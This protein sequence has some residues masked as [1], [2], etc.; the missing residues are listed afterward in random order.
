MFRVFDRERNENVALKLLYAP[1]ATTLRGLRHEL[2]LMQGV[3][4]P[5]LLSLYDV[6][7]LGDHGFLCMELV[8]GCDLQSH[9]RTSDASD[10]D[11]T[12][13]ARVIALL[14]GALSVLHGRFLV[15]RDV[16]PSNVRLRADGTPVLL[17]YGLL[18]HVA[19]ADASETGVGTPAYMS[20]EQMEG[21]QVGPA[22]DLYSLGVMLH[23]LLTGRLPPSSARWNESRDTTDPPLEERP[24]IPAQV[25]DLCRRLLSAKSENRPVPRQIVAALGLDEMHAGISLAPPLSFPRTFVARD[26]QLLQMDRAFAQAEAQGH[27]VRI[28]GKPQSGKSALLD[29]AIERMR[30]R[31][32]ETLLLRESFTT[33]RS[34]PYGAID[35]VARAVAE[36][37]VRHPQALTGLAVERAAWAREVFPALGSV[38]ALALA[39]SGARVPDLR[40][41]RSR[42]FAFVSDLLGHLARTKPVIVALDDV[43]AAPRD[44]LQL[45]EVLTRRAQ[46]GLFWIATSLPNTAQSSNTVWQNIRLP[47]LSTAELATLAAQ[48][49][50]H[51]CVTP[52]SQNEL[53]PLSGSP[54]TLLTLVADRL[55]GGRAQTLDDAYLARISSLTPEALEMLQFLCAVDLE[56][57]REELFLASPLSAESRV[58]SL[59]RLRSAALVCERQH[60]DGRRPLHVAS[61]RLRELVEGQLSSEA[62]VALAR[63]WARAFAGQGPHTAYERYLCHQRAGDVE[64]AADSAR[65]LAGRADAALGFGRAAELKQQ[66]VNLPRGTS[67]EVGRGDFRALGDTLVLDGR[68]LEAADA[69]LRAAQ[70]ANSAER[71]DLNRRRATLL[72]RSGEVTAGTDAIKDVLESLGLS[73]PS[74]SKRALFSLLWWRTKL[75]FRGLKFQAKA[76]TMVSQLDLMRIDALLSMANVLGLVDAFRG[77]ELQ[78]R[79]LFMALRAGESRH[80]ARALVQEANAS[81]TFEPP[82]LKKTNALLATAEQLLAHTDDAYSRALLTMTRGLIAFYEFRPHDARTLL[83]QAE[84]LFC[85]ECSDVE[86][87]LGN[88]RQ[89]L[90]QTLQFQE[91]YA[92]LRVRT[93]E[94]L[95]EAEA[96]GD[97]YVVTNLTMLGASF[98]H[99]LDS[100]PEAALQGVERVMPVWNATGEFYLQHFF[101]LL[102]R[103]SIASHAH[104]RAGLDFLRAAQAR[105]ERS[106]LLKS[107]LVRNTMDFSLSQAILST[108][109]HVAIEPTERDSLLKECAAIAK[110]LGKERYP[111]MALVATTID[112]SIAFARG[113]LEVAL[114][115]ADRAIAEGQ[116]LGIP[117]QQWRYTIACVRGD[118]EQAR[119]LADEMRRAGVRDPHR[120]SFA[121]VPTALPY[122]RLDP[123]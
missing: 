63:A 104:S 69:Y 102:A 28:E 82:P 68:P 12:S 64:L 90:L 114:S 75:A 29:H 18:T 37:L 79:A 34:T 86:W 88:A 74:T 14:A 6:G 3:S 60:D 39:H 51:A 119:I 50:Q 38:S 98:V 24:G 92:E 10:F 70:A 33:S 54:T 103:T 22:S 91:A 67:H 106:L 94:H 77:S 44:A 123:V 62:R 20:P 1:S 46:P 71:L 27:C 9:L 21:K 7:T 105:L 113:E 118:S 49:F 96:R 2:A 121:Q 57:T 122:S 48:A 87:E 95:R 13:V 11:M 73:L 81:A 45:L 42:A 85:D 59:M 41:R 72:L 31:S 99:L 109:A 101:E 110:R 89:F 25:T 120:F 76:T 15:H 52:S 43:D 97:H 93:Q 117:G 47:A 61:K 26:A 80:L 56:P 36:H 100:D 23:E 53:P 83:E 65:M 17:D 5:S 40:E 16:K 108:V 78:T 112:A 107:P 55:L 32:P 8:E 66:L 111:M 115:V 58:E 4:H 30:A 19:H 116:S 84:Q 35:E